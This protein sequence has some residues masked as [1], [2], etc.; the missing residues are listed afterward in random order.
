VLLIMNGLFH[1]IR[2]IKLKHFQR[3]EKS[4]GTRGT[5]GLRK[6]KARCRMFTGITITI[7]ET[8]RLKPSL[9]AGR[10]FPDSRYFL[11]SRR[12][13]SIYNLASRTCN[14]KNVCNDCKVHPTYS[15]QSPFT[16]AMGDSRGSMG[17]SWQWR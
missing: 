3:V 6:R 9:C 12:P 2:L 8:R 1:Q 4:K 7:K 5:R 11:K 14:R 13:Y 17:A 15:Q 16:N 10:F